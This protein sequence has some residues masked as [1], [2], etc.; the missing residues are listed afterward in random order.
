MPDTI[1]LGIIGTGLAVEKLHWPAL[2]RLADRFEVVA[3]SNRGREN[4]EHFSS[5]SGTPMDAF[6]SDYDQLLKRD[7]IDTVLISLPI[8]LNL[9]VTREALQAGKDVICEKP[10][11][12]NALEMQEFVELEAEYPDRTVLIG[13]NWFYRDD[14]RFARSL[15][16]DQVI[17]NVHTVAW[18]AVSQL[19]PRDGEFSSTPWRHHA[20]Y[21][22]GH[23]LDGGVHQVAQMRLLCGDIERLAGGTSDANSMFE[24]PSDLTL[25]MHFV[26][27]AIGNYTAIYPEFAVP[28]EPSD[29]RLY[30]TEGVMSIAGKAVRVFRPDGKVERWQIDQL[31]GGYYNEFLNFY[32]ARTGG[33]P[34]IGTISQSV[35]N[36][37]WVTKGLASA[38]EGRMMETDE[39]PIPLSAHAVPLW[40]PA[41]ADGIF[42]GLESTVS[43]EVVSES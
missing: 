36:M 37:E 38:A 15:L 41:G 42:D 8:P 1:R 13:E 33:A 27:G 19:V 35:R 29:M 26:S 9:P 31:D 4:A 17:G 7:D 3:F 40:K 11:G 18:R 25:A 39:G 21:V 16:D 32:E 2:K 34:L 23:H 24:G 14:L 5:Y 43:H 6:I 20:D 30:G 12:A 22:G 10:T 28:E